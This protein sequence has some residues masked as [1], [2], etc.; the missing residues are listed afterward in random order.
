LSFDL[1]YILFVTILFGLIIGSFL[2]MC[3]YRLPLGREKGPPDFGSDEQEGNEDS[4]ENEADSVVDFS[5]ETPELSAETS[6]AD[7]THVKISIISPARSFC[8]HCKTQLAWYN[9][10]PFFSWLFQGGK[11]SYCNAPISAM[12]PIVELLSGVTAL[13]VMNKFLFDAHYSIATAILVYVFCCS[14]IVI[15]FIDID[16]YIIPNKI[17]YPGT[18]IGLIISGLNQYT[19][20]F[21]LPVNQ[22]F[23]DAIWG[24]LAGAGFLWFIGKTYEVLR[25]HQGLGLGDVK[26]LAVIGVLFGAQCSVFTIF[27]GSV[28]GAVLGVAVLLFFR[29][30]LSR[31]LPFGPYLAI[32]TYIYLFADHKLLERI[33]PAAFL[34]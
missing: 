3:I 15:T 32:A 7:N 14:L 33:I 6:T 10:I 20:W 22:T 18:A 31:P 9:N 25:G 21:S 4:E 1:A 28:V 19:Q 23:L 34:L 11:C 8:P 16:Y 30:T 12:Y 26:L 2:S 5:S 27:M 24:F 29:H 13:L 17:T